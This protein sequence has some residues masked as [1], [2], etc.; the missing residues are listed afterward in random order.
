MSGICGICE[1]GRDVDARVLAPMLDALALPDESGRK[2]LSAHSVALGVAQRWIFQNAAV[3]EKVSIVADADFID[4]SGPS[5]A[6][7]IRRQVVV[8][9]PRGRHS[10]GAK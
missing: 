9:F 8:C 2:T 7:S 10:H 1:P 5:D 4:F 6:L 3:F